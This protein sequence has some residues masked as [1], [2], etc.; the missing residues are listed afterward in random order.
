MDDQQIR[1]AINVSK[2]AARKYFPFAK[3]YYPNS[4]YDQDDLEQVAFEEIWR[5][6]IDK[7]ELLCDGRGGG[8]MHSRARWAI[9]EE[10]R[11]VYG[12]RGQ[13]NGYERNERPQVWSLDRERSLTDS[14]GGDY[15]RTLLDSIPVEEDFSIEDNEW[16]LKHLT[17][18]Q[19]EFISYFMEGMTQAE[20][21]RKLEVSEANISLTMKAAR[22]RLQEAGI[23]S[24]SVLSGMV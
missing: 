15:T 20:I 17:S 8:W 9:I 1:D 22:G 6:G 4:K 23:Y 19:R 3:G 16:V 5:T 7:P 18:R 24:E 11:R 13:T 12:R 21:A 2:L 10:M 14:Q